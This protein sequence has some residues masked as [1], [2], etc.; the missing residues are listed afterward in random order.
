MSD[1]SGLNCV[2]LPVAD[3]GSTNK[4]GANFPTMAI[5]KAGN[6]YAVW[7]QAPIDSSGEVIGD[8]VLKYSFSTDQGNT[9]AA[10]IQIQHIGFTRGNS[11]QQRVCLGRGWRRWTRGHRLVRHAWCRPESF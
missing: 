9:W 11:A 3:L 7:E 1:P 10:P 8:T 2:D 5:D 6:L 4:T